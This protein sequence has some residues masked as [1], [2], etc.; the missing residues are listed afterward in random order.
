MWKNISPLT[1]NTTYIDKNNMKWQLC[2]FLRSIAPSIAAV[3]KRTISKNLV[4]YFKT[5][6][7]SVAK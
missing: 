5:S 3:K 7:T 2:Y 6:Q 4:A 1:V